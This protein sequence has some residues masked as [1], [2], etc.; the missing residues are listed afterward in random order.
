[1]K[2]ESSQVYAERVD[3]IPGTTSKYYVLVKGRP[4][5][6]IELVYMTLY[7]SGDDKI[8]N[9][10]RVFNIRGI[11]ARIDNGKDINAKDTEVYECPVYIADGHELGIVLEGEKVDSPCQIFI[12]YLT[13]ID[14]D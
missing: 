8:K 9:V 11:Q 10:W 13:H 5:F 3:L 1:M 14:K 7:P 4:G 12:H 6:V 2:I